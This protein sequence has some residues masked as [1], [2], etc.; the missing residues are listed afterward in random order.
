MTIKK[1][2]SK[3]LWIAASA[4]LM[5][6]GGT[7]V[8]VTSGN[9]VSAS[10]EV[11]QSST[12]MFV[13]GTLE[14]GQ[15]KYDAGGRRPNQSIDYQAKNLLLLDGKQY[16]ILGKTKIEL[17]PRGTSNTVS[18]LLNGNPYKSGDYGI[19]T[20]DKPE[21]GQVRKDTTWSFML[22]Q[23]D[24]DVSGWTEGPKVSYA[25]DD[26]VSHSDQTYAPVASYLSINQSFSLDSLI[27][28]SKTV[29]GKANANEKIILKDASGTNLIKDN[30]SI[31]SDNSGNYTITLNRPVK[32]N[33]E[34][35]A[36]AMND[37]T[38]RTLA[39]TVVGYD[40]SYH[41]P[42]VGTITAGTQKIT[43]EVIPEDAVTAKFNESP[44]D[45]S[46]ITVDAGGNYTINFDKPLETTD[47]LSITSQLDSDS[48]KN[49]T[50]SNR[51]PAFSLDYAKQ[52]ANKQLEATAGNVK[53][54][55]GQTQLPQKYQDAQVEY[56]NQVL[57]S[58][59]TAVDSLASDKNQ[60]DVNEA[61]NS[62]NTTLNAITNTSSSIYQGIQKYFAD[63]NYTFTGTDN[64]DFQKGFN[65]AKDGYASESTNTKSND[66]QQ[67]I[68]YD[69][70]N[71]IKDALANPTSAQKN[72]DDQQSTSYKAGYNDTLD[73]INKALNKNSTIDNNNQAQA[74]GYSEVNNGAAASPIDN[75][76]DLQSHT[77]AYKKGYTEAQKGHNDALDKSKEAVASNSNSKIYQDSYNQTRAPFQA[78]KDYLTNRSS[79][80]QYSGGNQ[81]AYN[82]SYS[83][84]GDAISD[85]NGG[86]TKS[87]D[88]LGT[89][90]KSQQ[91]KDSYR[92]MAVTQEA[93]ADVVA[94]RGSQKDSSDRN[95]SDTEKSVYQQA[96]D[97]ATSAKN[98]S[99]YDEQSTNSLS[100]DYAYNTMLGAK[101]Y[102]NGQP[103]SGSQNF[104]EG[105]TQAQK[106]Y[107]TESQGSHN[108]AYIYGQNSKSQSTT[109]SSDYQRNQTKK[110]GQDVSYGYG[111][112]GAKDGN[113]DAL[114]GNQ[115]A[116]NNGTWS[117][118]AQSYQDSYKA[119]YT[120]ASTARQGM[121]DALTPKEAV[122]KRDA[123]YMSGYNG[124]KDG[125]VSQNGQSQA[126]KNAQYETAYNYAQGVKSAL[127]TPNGVHDD[128][129]TNKAYQAGYN[130]TQDGIKAA[131]ES[132]T[133]TNDSKKATVKGFNEI[134]NGAKAYQLGQTDLTDK[135]EAYKKGFNEAK[136]G[137]DDAQKSDATAK[138]T[139][140]TSKQYQDS[141]N[142]TRAAIQAQIDY[143][144]NRFDTNKNSYSGDNQTAYN[145]SYSGMIDDISDY[146]GGTAKSLDTLGTNNK[147]QQYKDS[148]RMMTVTQE[149]MADVVASRGSQKDT[150]DRNYSQ[151][152]KT[153]YQTAFDAATSAKNSSNYNEQS[154]NSLSADYAYNTMLGAKAYANGQPNSGSQNFTEGYTQAQKG[155]NTESQDSHNPAYTYGQKSKS[156]SD[157]GSSDYQR[158]QTK[159][160]G[161]DVSYGYGYDGSKD[162]NEDALVGNQ[163]AE[164]ND[165][166]SSKSQSYQDSYKAAYT[167]G[168]TARQ[169][170]QDALT[171]KEA[172]SKRDADYMSG[173][174][175][176]KDGL[177]SQNGQSQADK[178]AQYETAYNYAQGVKSALA[179]P[180]GVH[181]D[182]AT[183]KAYQAG[184]NDTQDGIK[185]ATES[186]TLTNDSKKAT[187]KGFNEINSGAKAYQAG[188]TDL[189][190]KT[191]AYKKGYTESKTGHD[192]AQKSKSDD[193]NTSKTRQYQVSF[194]LTRAG[195]LGSSDYL[196][197]GKQ[198]NLNRYDSK[199]N[200]KQSYQDGFE[201]AKSGQTVGMSG[202]M[203]DNNNNS[204]SY[205]DGYKTG[206]DKGYSSYLSDV[207]NQQA[208]Y[209]MAYRQGVNQAAQDFE[210]GVAEDFANKSQFYI[211]GYKS[212][213]S[214]AVKSTVAYEPGYGVL[215]WHIV[216][217]KPVQ[218]KVYKQHH[219]KI[220]AAKET[221]NIDG[222]SYT[223][224][225]AT[226]NNW[227]QT[228][229]LTENPSSPLTG[230]VS[231]R[232][233]PTNY[234]VYLRDSK[235]KMTQQSV[236]LDSSW[237]VFEQKQING[238][239]YY[240][241]G[242]DNQWI[243]AKYANLG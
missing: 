79:N 16:F 77:E 118:K 165:T 112:D 217:G 199:E 64:G 30:D 183:N 57:S 166:W 39:T 68:A 3:K 142:A 89:N 103:N 61:V 207:Q 184:Y 98:S 240:R 55:I 163:S 164:N 60:S 211:D 26:T 70:A 213:A 243:E 99:N 202:R 145:E 21:A 80:N 20:Y 241:I 48:S 154:T 12:S 189:T 27:D 200:Q 9:V 138:P 17:T 140:G 132:E 83:G 22:P 222:V 236:Y 219:N 158:N 69:Y 23:I 205:K 235:G 206:Y 2:N 109:G 181:D 160:S 46:K 238:Q 105:Y 15:A 5:L 122:S 137:H 119:A 50:L 84:M 157:T 85:Y 97:A 66:K 34:I 117:S 135:T 150:Q 45:S 171:P 191:E 221:K 91:Y 65:G 208:A 25:P 227:I 29:T 168:S 209:M 108:P 141:Y 40:S 234:A 10:D 81:T 151:T 125:L 7:A 233:V 218:T 4:S 87:L 152:E 228:Q 161:Q 114:V 201:G 232:N 153:I 88:T 107:N 110:P 93:M 120:K 42:K 210:S 177:V 239:L 18:V 196:N 74:K 43:G 113:E 31:T 124:A 188:Q 128:S 36:V 144:T 11:S 143:L 149:A 92:M 127:A 136:A 225:A 198:T 32:Y 123:D 180:N 192:D 169:G 100:A 133:L 156:Q 155:Y 197:S 214:N 13:N 190:N 173:Y 102:A 187:V 186:E 139:N 237:R 37:N 67:T 179:T 185:A 176:A 59:Q 126:D 174:N 82:E 72:T 53:S 224:L 148:Y 204:Q 220:Y 172:V 106:G 28:S 73:S 24:G 223:K 35:T 62:G 49:S 226:D 38:P 51:K 215:V 167:K 175:G 101:A 115:S 162:G 76:S 111:Y 194:Q 58:V 14:R 96:F 193:V 229:Y 121:Q 8:N 216:D 242:N 52:K 147:S 170:M 104:T 44:I 86:T 178:N 230:T 54:A 90:N 63:K 130:D 159:Q 95:Y 203:S 94:P 231:V 41:T 19:G 75:E 212:L 33:E 195:L 134:N 146:N 116:E 47:N 131:T 129:A 78:Q 6:L 71:G 56:V 182:S 1:N